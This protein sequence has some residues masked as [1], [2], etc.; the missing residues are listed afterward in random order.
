MPIVSCLICETKF[1][2]KPSHKLLGWGKF[3]SVECRTKGQLKGKNVVCATCG[4]VVYKPPLA[5]KRSKSGK[6]F[7]SKVCQTIWRNT[8][9]FVEENHRNWKTGESAY[10][11]ILKASS[12]VEVC[13]LC[14]TEDKRV[15]MVH[16]YDKNR[17]NNKI[18]NLI[19]LCNNCHYLV[20]HYED[21]KNKLKMILKR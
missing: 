19:W 17:Q 1:Y 18:G 5:L 9:L 8:V 21:E 6:F 15:L 12:R 10:R 14:K 16:H 2:V 4:E 7:C 13:I 11:R 20:H 3:C